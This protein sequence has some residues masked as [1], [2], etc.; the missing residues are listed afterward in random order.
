MR[1]RSFKSFPFLIILII[2]K[3]L[4]FYYASRLF[5]G[6]IQT[7]IEDKLMLPPVSKSPKKHLSELVTVIIRDFELHENDVTLTSYSFINTF[8]TMHVVIM[9][10]E[11]PY[12]PLD[13][14]LTNNTLPYI[15]FVK[16]SPELKTSYIDQYSV[17]D[18]RS[19]YVLFVP[20]ST[21]ITSR[22]SLQSMVNAIVKFP[23]SIVVAAVKNNKN[24]LECLR[25]SINIR[26]WTL[27]YDLMKSMV[28]DAVSGKHVILLETT[29]LRMLS[30]AFLMPFPHSLYLQTAALKIKVNIIKGA[31]FHEGKP[32]FRS[33]HAQWRQNQVQA[34]RLK[35]LY[36]TFKI[37]QV[38]RET[39]ITE[40]YGC[41]KE[42]SRCFG[43]ILDSMPSYLY[44]KK[45]TPP[46]CLSNLRKT[47]KHLFSILDETGIRYWLEAG[48]LLGAM[49]NGDILPWDHDVDVGFIREDQDRCSWLKMAKTKP[50]IDSKGFLWEKAT[51]GNFYRVHFS[52]TNRIFVNLFPFYSKNGTMSKDSWYTS[53]KNMEFPEHFLH[54]MS[55]IDFIGRTVPSP[56]NIRDFLELKFGKGS[57]ET[58]EY[59]NPRKLKFP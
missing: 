36:N 21:R 25:M 22:Q 1:L 50:V 14:T 26:E 41:T 33:H 3:I 30:N 9:Y 46:C 19:K 38:V 58:P 47:A 15:K 55:S 27:K 10:D 44:E 42:T 12:P 52:K 54:P 28:C 2:I 11:L 45:W 34:E 32:I 8:A 35:Q 37:K 4:T 16:L 20:D 17:S 6:L 53:H 49:R 59:P 40:W 39:G 7:N 24:T 23:R 56:N 57:I 48:S 18:I 51:E 13:V 31:F 5:S 43:T 29:T